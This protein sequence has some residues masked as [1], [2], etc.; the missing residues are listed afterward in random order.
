MEQN[1]SQL[2]CPGCKNREAGE[3]SRPINCA[4][5][6]KWWKLGE[7]KNV[8]REKLTH[9]LY[10]LSSLPLDELWSSTQQTIVEC[11]S[12]VLGCSKKGGKAIDKQTWWFGTDVQKII[13]EKKKALKKWF[14]TKDPGDLLLYKEA[15]RKAKAAVATAKE[16]HYRSLYEELNSAEG[17]KMYPRP[18][19]RHWKWSAA[20]KVDCGGEWRQSTASPGPKKM[21]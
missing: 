21:P 13:A 10:P 7:H 12:D 2:T 1:F 5:R 6:I 19:D 3:L 16:A 14:A 20:R 15:K 9:L 8:L 11:A 17:E 4:A 18:H